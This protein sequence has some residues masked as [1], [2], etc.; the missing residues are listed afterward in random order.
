MPLEFL[1]SQKGKPQLLVNGHL[2]SFHKALENGDRTWKCVNY[3]KSSCMARVH[4]DRNDSNIVQ[5]LREHNHAADAAKLKAK[6]VVNQ[7]RQRAH[8]TE[9]SPHQ[10]IA[11]VTAGKEIY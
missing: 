1:N 4:T 9:E 3:N 2:F 8:E 11:N 5:H 6:S 7:L 10:I